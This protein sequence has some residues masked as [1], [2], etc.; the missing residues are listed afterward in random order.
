MENHLEAIRSALATDAT[1]ELRSQGAAACH[2]LLAILEPP[3]PVAPPSADLATLANSAIGM[4]RS[5]PADQLLDLA[6][7]TLRS[8]LPA[9]VNID[10]VRPISFH[11]IPP[12]PRVP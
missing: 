1:P 3:P 11:M 9:G 7:A 10:P 2:A 5:V 6:I 4:L 8:R 12:P